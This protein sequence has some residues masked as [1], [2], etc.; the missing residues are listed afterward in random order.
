MFHEDAPLVEGGQGRTEDELMRDISLIQ[1]CLVIGLGGM[2]LVLM[3]T[4]CVHVLPNETPF[5]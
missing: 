5:H 4:G 2:V 3:V 1:W